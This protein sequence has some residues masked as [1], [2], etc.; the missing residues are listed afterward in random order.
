MKTQSEEL[1]E[2]I[3]TLLVAEKL[4]L[5]DDMAKLCPKM[6]GGNMKASDWLLAVEKAMEK[7]ASQ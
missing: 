3:V 1:S 2:S 6:A 4:L 5:Q 7:E